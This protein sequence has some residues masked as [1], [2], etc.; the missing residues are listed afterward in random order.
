V[1]GAVDTDATG[2]GKSEEFEGRET[3]NGTEGEVKLKVGGAGLI[4]VA[5]ARIARPSD[6]LE[7]AR[8]CNVMRSW[9]EGK[10]TLWPG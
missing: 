8:D 6:W 2:I 4:I 7:R 5:D 1:N 9:T 3:T 10:G